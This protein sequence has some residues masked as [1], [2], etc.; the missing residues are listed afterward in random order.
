MIGY[1]HLEVIFVIGVH[2][3]LDL[4]ISK[5]IAPN[6]YMLTMSRY[7]AKEAEFNYT[8]HMHF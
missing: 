1:F 3:L 4:L 2:A 5:H 8:S 6:Y 7:F